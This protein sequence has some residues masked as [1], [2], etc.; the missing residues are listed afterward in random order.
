[1]FVTHSVPEAVYLSTRVVVMSSRPGRI[2]GT[3]AIDLPQPRG[4]ATRESPRFFELVN[5][6]RERLHSGAI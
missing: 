4:E 5:E 1:V 6:V 3:V 2:T